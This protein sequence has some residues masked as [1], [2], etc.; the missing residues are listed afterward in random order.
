[1]AVRYAE[2]REAAQLEWPFGGCTM[3]ASRT[4][5]AGGAAMAVRRCL[6]GLRCSYSLLRVLDGALLRLRR[7]LIGFIVT[8]NHLV[9]QAECK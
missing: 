6:H 7:V 8:D 9:R 4:P 2:M 3:A 1:M 5:T